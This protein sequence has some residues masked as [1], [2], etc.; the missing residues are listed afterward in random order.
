MDNLEAGR[1]NM[2]TIE[3]VLKEG[4]EK[5][6]ALL[7]TSGKEQPLLFVNWKIQLTSVSGLNVR[8]LSVMEEHCKPYK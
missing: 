5:T 3:M 6:M 4:G 2:A 8:G 1:E 7:Y